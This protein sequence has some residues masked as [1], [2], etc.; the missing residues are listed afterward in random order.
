LIVV[1]ASAM[2]DYL[3]EAGSEGAWARLRIRSDGEVSAPHLI[4]LEV[5]SSLRKLASR[6][7]IAKTTAELAL[8][9]F[10]ELD[11]IRYPATPLLGR[12]WAL[13][14]HL[15]VYDAAYVSLSEA[16]AV[17]LVTTDARLARSH[18]HGAEIIAFSA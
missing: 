6:R 2:V 5:A 12:I 7:E 10:R 8:N 15:T 11:V 18:G 14:D 1:D 3:L 9:D 13:R 17:P 4:D 16:L